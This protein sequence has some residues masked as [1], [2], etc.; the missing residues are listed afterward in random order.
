[1][2]KLERF[3]TNEEKPKYIADRIQTAERVD[4]VFTRAGYY[5]KKKEELTDMQGIAYGHILQEWLE[6]DTQWLDKLKYLVIFAL[7]KDIADVGEEGIAN[8]LGKEFGK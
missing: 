2:E 8:R 1:M 5:W 6:E 7:I 3:I 4:K